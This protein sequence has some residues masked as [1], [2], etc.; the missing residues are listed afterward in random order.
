MTKIISIG[1]ILILQATIA[2]CEP[3]V[4]IVKDD[5]TMEREPMRH[6]GSLYLL[7]AK[8]TIK[9][10][11]SSDAKDI[12]ITAE[13]TECVESCRLDCWEWS[14]SGPV[15]KIKYLSSGDKETFEFVIA[16]MARSSTIPPVSP[17]V[18]LKIKDVKPAK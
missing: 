14:K 11:G 3:R 5:I 4:V 16:T 6:G 13:C 15:G 7:A 2:W 8:G 1:L 18:S 12:I 9:N 17:A 10:V